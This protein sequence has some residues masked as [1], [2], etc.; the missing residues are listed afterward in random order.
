MRRRQMGLR[1]I[2]GLTEPYRNI[3][4]F[5]TSHSEALRINSILS[6]DFGDIIRISK[7]TRPRSLHVMNHSL[8]QVL[9]SV[10]DA[11]V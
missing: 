8:L 6:Q 11:R 9:L 7:S 5:L 1:L 10:G 3:L 2:D 4:I